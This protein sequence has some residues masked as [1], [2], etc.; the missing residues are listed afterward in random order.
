MINLTQHEKDVLHGK[1]GNR[2]I[3]FRYDL[4]DNDGNKKDTLA[5]VINCSID[6]KSLATINRTARM[7][8]E[9]SDNIDWLNDYV[10]PFMMVKDGNTWLEWSLG[11]FMLSSSKR[12]EENGEVTREIECYDTMQI[13]T[14]DKVDSRYFISAGSNYINE[15]KKILNNMGLVKINI[16][17]SSK[18]LTVD[19]EYEIGTS[20]LSIINSLL[21]E[22]NY[23]S[24]IVDAW[25]YY[26]S[27]PYVLPSD[28]AVDYTYMDD[29][30]SIIYNGV[31]EE[32]DL[33]NVPNKFIVTASNPEELPLT[34]IY[35]ND[36][37]NSIVSTANRGRVITDFREIDNIADQEA[38]DSYT[39]RIAEDASNVYGYLILETAI[40][41]HHEFLDCLKVG[42][43][44]LTVSDEYIE[45]NW[46]M[47]LKVGAKMRHTVRKVV[48]I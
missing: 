31:E 40:M 20:K 29:E 47:Q 30:L 3:K 39:R 6:Y 7:K 1:K 12:K 44:A 37:V 23:Y 36:N 33:F 24:L 15:I 5:N 8:I 28:R 22:L 2:E 14:D 41:P 27:S 19:R 46:S 18:T 32:L 43:T 25:G 48:S 35:E 17:N 11:I 13:L 38:L 45:T 26:T 4:L 34:S 16:V 10:Q 42:Y 21:A 9:E